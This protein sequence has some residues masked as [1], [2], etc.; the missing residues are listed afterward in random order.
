MK[1]LKN[2]GKYAILQYRKK[3]FFSHIKVMID[4]TK[5]E[6]KERKE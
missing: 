6:R 2:N 5:K 4:T 3:Y 1:I